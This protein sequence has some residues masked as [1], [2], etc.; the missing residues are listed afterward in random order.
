MTDFSLR[1]R[2]V[3]PVS[4]GGIRRLGWSLAGRGAAALL[5]L[6]PM[7]HSA[8]AGEDWVEAEP[9]WIPSLS[10]RFDTFDYKTDP[11]VVNHLNPPSQEGIQTNANRELQFLSEGELQGPMFEGLPG[12]PRLFASAGMQFNPYA[13][14]VVFETGDLK[15]DPEGAIRKFE[16]LRRGD[17][18]RYPRDDP[19]NCLNGDP[20][21]CTT[22]VAGDFEGQ[23][24][25][26]EAKFKQS[27]FAAFGVAFGFPVG[28]SLLLQ[29]K[30]SIAYNVDEILFS[31]AITTVTED[32]PSTWA[33]P[34]VPE[35]TVNR[36]YGG[37]R[38]TDHSLGPGIELGLVLFRAARPLRVSLYGDA[39]FLW[40]LG[41]RTTTFSDSL[42]TYQVRRDAFG[43]RAGAG[44]RL[45]WMGFGGR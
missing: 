7:A 11:S 26:I 36:A 2:V 16:G 5:A 6:C 23:G 30:P 9:R 38:T 4:R 45:S 28:E 19:R 10:F 29:V 27:W 12:R 25:E 34:D 35:F 22:A 14:D 21:F 37:D 13:A 41:D 3:T 33:D 15:G 1:F 32:D 20:P 40:L 24:S 42:A 43:I 44:V 17:V 8:W 18:N 39:R 31:G